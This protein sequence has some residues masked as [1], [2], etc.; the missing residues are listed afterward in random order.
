VQNS[1]FC[2]VKITPTTNTNLP[3]SNNLQEKRNKKK[4]F[5]KQKKKKKF[6]NIIK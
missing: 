1:S 4:E 3:H 6:K 2:Y 5:E